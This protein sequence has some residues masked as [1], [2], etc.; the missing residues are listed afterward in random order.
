MLLL[1]DRSYLVFRC[2]TNVRMFMLLRPKLKD[3]MHM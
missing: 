1:C 3:T 2:L